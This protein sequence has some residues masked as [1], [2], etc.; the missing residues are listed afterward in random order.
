MKFLLFS[1][2]GIKRLAKING[3]ILISGTAFTGYQYPELT[4]NPSQFLNAMVRACRCASTGILM[5]SDY[6]RVKEITPET[7]HIAS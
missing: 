6:L 4:K 3:C 5:A 2:K 1:S 7:H